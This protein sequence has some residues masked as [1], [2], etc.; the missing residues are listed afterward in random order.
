M[1]TKLIAPAIALVV[2]GVVLLILKNAVVWKEDPKYAVMRGKWESSLSNH[3]AQANQLEIYDYENEE[4]ISSVTNTH[5]ITDLLRRIRVNENESKSICFCLGEYW[6][7]FKEGTNEVAT[8]CVHAEDYPNA[9]L[10]WRRGEWP[11]HA[12]LTSESS[13]EFY[14]WIKNHK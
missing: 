5:E 3:I 11:A 7:I 2:C 8:I 12:E 14:N 10:H 6:L 13:T 4:V 9:R 1:K